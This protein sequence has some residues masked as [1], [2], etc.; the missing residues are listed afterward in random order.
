[1]LEINRIGGTPDPTRIERE[2]LQRKRAASSA[3]TT[4]D[5]VSISTEARTASNIV[6]FSEAVKNL[7]DI[8]Q[9]RVEQ[10]RK[11]IEQGTYRVYEIVEMVAE[12]ISRQ[13]VNE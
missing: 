9:E 2:D 7:P 4:Q 10:A 11:N 8:R 13:I 5:A 3:Q 1:M 12:R 6:Q